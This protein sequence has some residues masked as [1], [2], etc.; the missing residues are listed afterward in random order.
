VVFS[1][2]VQE[3]RGSLL[4]LFD[5][6]RASKGKQGSGRQKSE[7]PSAQVSSEQCHTVKTSVFLSA[8]GFEWVT[9]EV[10]YGVPHSSLSLVKEF[11]AVSVYV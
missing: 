2:G 11:L 3:F 8:D 4:R 7:D 6:L 9:L 10:R 5:K 1:S